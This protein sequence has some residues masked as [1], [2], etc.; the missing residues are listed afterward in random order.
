MP[1]ANI[2][3][4]TSTRQKDPI[5]S[6]TAGKRAFI[7]PVVKVI[8]MQ[9]MA[10]KRPAVFLSIVPVSRVNLHEFEYS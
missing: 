9:T 6:Y 3:N 10:R 4:P 5:K 2:D 7:S 1:T 8:K